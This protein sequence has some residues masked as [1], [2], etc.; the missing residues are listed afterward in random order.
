[1]PQSHRSPWK[2]S[3]PRGVIMSSQF[4]AALRVLGAAGDGWLTGLP[5]LIASLEADWS[6]TVGAALAGGNT[7]YVAE[8]VAHDGTPAVLK[9]AMPPGMPG[10]VPFAQ[11]LAALQLVGGDPYVRLLR[12]DGVRRAFLLERLGP[13]LASLGWPASRQLDT[14]VRTAARGW[15]PVTA[16]PFPTEAPKARWFGD[17][18]ARTWEDL[19]RPCPEAVAE[20]AVRYAAARAAAFDPRRAVLVHGDAHPFNLL[21]ARGQARGQAPGQA[22]GFRLIDPEGVAADPALELGVIIRNLK[23]GLAGRE[24]AEARVIMARNCQRAAR[25]AGEHA[26]QSAGADPEAIWQWAFIERV[27]NGLN[28][29]RIGDHADAEEF[30]TGA[31]KL[32][33]GYPG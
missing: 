28:L 12:Y 25:L 2:D 32:T 10:F 7:S 31:G 16:G 22:G 33:K 24:P 1:M 9:V 5:E 18:V 19:G 21:Q 27:A 11:Q 8:A 30:L 6:V 26:G 14:L 17:Y 4:A 29:L 13:P 20:Q 15:R 3:D 23:D